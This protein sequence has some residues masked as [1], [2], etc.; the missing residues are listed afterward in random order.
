MD[1]AK[2][3]FMAASALKSFQNASREGHEFLLGV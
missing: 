1:V 3:R 2:E